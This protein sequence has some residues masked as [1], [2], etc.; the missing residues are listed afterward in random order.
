M[1]QADFLSLTRNFGK[2]ATWDTGDFDYNGSATLA[3]LLTLTRRFGKTLPMSPTLA[4][5]QSPPSNP[6]TIRSATRFSRSSKA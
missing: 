2:P 6:V 5:A 3:D 1:N 4:P